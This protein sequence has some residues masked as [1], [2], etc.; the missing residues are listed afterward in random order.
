MR[1]VAFLLLVLTLAA[2]SQDDTKL[3]KQGDRPD[4]PPP[5]VPAA[6]APPAS[7]EPAPVYSAPRPRPVV[8]DVLRRLRGG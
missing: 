4:I 3:W 8:Q 1:R 6:A 2:C 7:T 5:P